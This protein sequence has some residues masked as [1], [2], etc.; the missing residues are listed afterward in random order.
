[1]VEILIVLVR[2]I[3][4]ILILLILAEVIL[5]YILSPYHPVRATISKIVDPILEPI[6]R[7]VPPIKMIDFSPLILLIVIQIL[8]FLL[9]TI[10][11]TFL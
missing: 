10:L 4:Q 5:S 8:E 11:Q 2:V 1:M 6:R 7:L 9:V 3:A